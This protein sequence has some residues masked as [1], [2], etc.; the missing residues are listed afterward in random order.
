LYSNRI[1]ALCRGESR[2]VTSSRTTSSD[3]ELN[4]STKSKIF[5]TALFQLEQQHRSE[6]VF[7]YRPLCINRLTY[8]SPHHSSASMSSISRIAPRLTR[9]LATLPNAA[10]GGVPL[11]NSHGGLKD[12]DR[13]FSNLYRQGDNGIKGAMVSFHLF[14]LLPFFPGLLFS[15]LEEGEGPRCCRAT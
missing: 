3:R 9:S 8:L 11:I 7:A 10:S 1:V 15:E 14:L 6:G 12:Q 13:I 4:P 2:V 5:V